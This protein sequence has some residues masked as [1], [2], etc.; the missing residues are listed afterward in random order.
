MIKAIYAGTF[1]PITNGHIDIIKRSLVF[2]DKLIVAVGINPG[3]NPLFSPEERESLIDD[4]L[5]SAQDETMDEYV[6]TEKVR[7]K[8][9][10]GLL[11]EFARSEGATILIRGIRNV[12]DFEYEINLAGINK[13]LAPEIETVFLPTSPDLMTV[14]SSMVK[15]IAKFKGMIDQFVQPSVASAIYEKVK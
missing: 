3:K 13:L 12:S 11:G 15:E 8:T 1:D 7:V 6:V 5:E 10:S 2:C 9:F 14:S 4:S